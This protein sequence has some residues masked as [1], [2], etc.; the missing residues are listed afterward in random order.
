MSEQAIVN[1]L[2]LY[3]AA[4]D[5]HLWDL[6]DE[7]FAAEAELDYPGAMHWPNRAAFKRDFSVYHEALRSH[8]HVM[9]NHQVVIAGDSAN[10]LTYGTYRLYEHGGDGAP[11]SL[12]EGLCWYD[13]QFTRTAEGWR[14]HK[15]RARVFWHRGTTPQRAVGGGED[16][17]AARAETTFVDSLTAD[18]KAGLVAYFN[19]LQRRR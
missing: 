16:V 13:D 10:S 12:R 15:R 9:T 2:N 1:V 5:S 19:A 6:F 14:I 18:A 17:L 4:L 7:V 11:E 8:Q 3:A